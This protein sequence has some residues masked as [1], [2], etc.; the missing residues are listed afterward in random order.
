MTDGPLP[1]EVRELIASRVSSIEQLDVL[2]VILRGNGPR[3]VS[4][5]AAALGLARET[6]GMRLFLLA[7]AGLL[8]AEGSGDV[9]YSVARAAAPLAP[10]L[11]IL[12]DAYQKDRRALS[13]FL[14]GE[15]ADPLKSFA[16]AFKLKKP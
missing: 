8:D 3:S 15:P 2:M 13:Q 11:Q 14:F 16:D 5:V 1:R 12:A 10:M 9:R 7:S 6:I 4:D